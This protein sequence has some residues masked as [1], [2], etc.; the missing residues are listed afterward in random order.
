MSRQT[1]GNHQEQK[2]SKK[3]VR[4]QVSNP[5]NQKSLAAKVIVYHTVKDLSKSPI[6][7]IQI[8]QP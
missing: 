1:A 2:A 8:G 5:T 3:A 6:V 7:L 4:K